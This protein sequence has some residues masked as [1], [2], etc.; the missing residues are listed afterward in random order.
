VKVNG[1]V[2]A[3][4]MHKVRWMV[5]LGMC[6][7]VG[8]IVACNADAKDDLRV[9]NPQT[10]DKRNANTKAE[11]V[12]VAQ[13]STGKSKAVT[14]PAADATSAQ[15]KNAPGQAKA[16]A[17]PVKTSAQDKEVLE[18]AEKVAPT[19][20]EVAKKLWDLA[21][22][23]L[24]EVKSSAYLKDLLKKNG[25]AITSEKTAGVPTAFIAE[26]GKGEPKIGI[27]LEYDALPG[28]G[29]EPVPK[30]QP[31]KDGV[32]AGHGCGHNLVGA[33]AMGAALTIKNMMVAKGIPGT[34]RVYGA[35]AEESE[36][37]KVFM[38]REGLFDDLDGMLHWHP[39]DFARV[40][41]VRMAAAQHMYIEFKGKTAHAGM[42]PW[43]GRSAL[44]AAEIFL[45]SVNMMR[46]H[47]EPTARIHYIIKE[48]GTATNVVPE[49]AVILLSY[50][51]ADRKRVNKGVAWIKDMAKGAALAT[52]TKGLAVDYFGIH[53]LLPNTPLADRMHR[54]LQ[55]VGLPEYTAEEQTFATDLQ[56]AA[57]LD[58][59]GMAK[60]I[61]PIPNEPN[62]GGFTDVGDVSYI[63]PTMGI[64]V[65]AFPQGIG[66]HTWMA[67]A[68]NGY[69][70]G[71]K[72]A[73]TASK[74]LALTG[75][76]LLTDP[77]LLKQ[78][79]A[80]FDKRTKGFTYKSPIPDMIKE[81]SGLPDDMRSFG[82]RAHLKATILKGVG[83]DNFGP[84]PKG[85]SHDR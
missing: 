65:P 73:V 27:L 4:L 32:T 11:P 38:A 47:V 63:T 7:S 57:G 28:L 18:A 35:A 84:H 48:A 77:E 49:R 21:E 59:T 60:K 24:L 29:N 25:F 74:V 13:A 10:I 37:A 44:D 34:L 3:L 41:K 46:E 19:V 20:E 70:I 54:H 42:A 76:D 2:S 72:S 58:P 14:Q 26:Y 61:D 68:S 51:D 80:D 40:A 1:L 79:K 83:D 66:L 17:K 39:S 75:I 55:T 81:P 33:G 71:F 6:A 45:H 16:I 82:T 56:K 5:V 36:G 12:G 43:E 67:T 78:A 30:K 69:S 50:R 9:V 31:R 53:D 23:S 22:V 85:H 52:Q 64:T 62:R 15:G 8:I